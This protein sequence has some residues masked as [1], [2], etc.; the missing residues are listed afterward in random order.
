MTVYVED[1]FKNP[2]EV[3][4]NLTCW[5]AWHKT[6]AFGSCRIKQ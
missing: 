2:Y 6:N 4:I 3:K 5:Q 1:N